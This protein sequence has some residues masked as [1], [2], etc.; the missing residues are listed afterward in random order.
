MNEGSKKT[1]K[2]LCFAV[3]GM[4]TFSFA[5][6]P[7]YNVF[8]EVTGLNGKIE[9]KATKETD[10]EIE[11][12]RDLSV[13]FVSHNNEQMPWAF[14][15]SED[16]IKIKTGKYHTTSFYVKNTTNKLMTA[17]AIPSVAPS[18][19]AAHLKKLE[20][21]CF[22]QQ[23]LAPGEEALLPVRLIFDDALPK[24]IKSVVLSYTIFDVTNY[25]KVQLSKDLES[26]HGDGHKMEPSV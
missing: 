9:L 4:F 25:D 13:Q 6:V 19:A 16:I 11:N 12:G 18:N 23:E 21:F 15:P 8:C 22:E 17:Q 7:L 1:I 10:I 5:L 26:N 24:S 3:L 2:T 20:C 14:K